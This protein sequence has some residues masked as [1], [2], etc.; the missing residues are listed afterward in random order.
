MKSAAV[1]QYWFAFIYSILSFS[2]IKSCST[3][4]NGR[5]SNRFP[6]GWWH[7]KGRV[8]FFPSALPMMI[9]SRVETHTNTHTEKHVSSY[10]PKSQPSREQKASGVMVI[11]LLLTKRDFCTS[12]WSFD[13]PGSQ[14]KTGLGGVCVNEEKIS[15]VINTNKNYFIPSP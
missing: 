6:E 15:P 13:T 7:Y 4:H 9:N 11:S 14:M 2:F 8:C 5:T 12:H 10:L 3:R 1:L